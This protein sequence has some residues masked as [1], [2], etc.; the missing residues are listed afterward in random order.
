MVVLVIIIIQPLGGPEVT[1]LSSKIR[2]E[3]CSLIPNYLLQ[4]LLIWREGRV[5]EHSKLG[6][7]SCVFESS[8]SCEC[9]T[10]LRIGYRSKGLMNT[11]TALLYY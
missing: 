9:S 6:A 3:R 2:A 5:V 1:V 11:E 4:F 8:A 10:M 7:V